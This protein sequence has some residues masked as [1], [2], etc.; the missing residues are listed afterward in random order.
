MGRY[1]RHGEELKSN[2]FCYIKSGL[3]KLAQA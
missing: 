1:E 2:R 3:V